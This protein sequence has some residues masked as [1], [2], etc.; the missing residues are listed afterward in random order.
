[1]RS[2][3]VVWF[4]QLLEEGSGSSIDHHVFQYHHLESDAS[5]DRELLEVP[6][7]GG[8]MGGI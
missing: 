6:E 3:W 2:S 4:D 7:E 5:Y 1:M 8:R